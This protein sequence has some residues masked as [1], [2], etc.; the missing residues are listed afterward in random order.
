MERK[1]GQKAEDSWE[2]HNKEAKTLLAEAEY[3]LHTS[4]AEEI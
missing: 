3:E 4:S 1:A 2:D